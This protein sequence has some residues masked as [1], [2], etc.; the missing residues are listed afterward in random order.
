[1]QLSSLQV[2]G[3]GGGALLDMTND[4]NVQQKTFPLWTCKFLGA[5]D[6]ELF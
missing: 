1:M 5:F 4:E 3:G 6:N 2:G